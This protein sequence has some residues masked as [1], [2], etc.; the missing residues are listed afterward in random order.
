MSNDLVLR[1]ACL[2]PVTCI[3]TC[4][5][6]ASMGMWRE[7]LRRIP[8]IGFFL[9]EIREAGPCKGAPT[10]FMVASEGDLSEGYG[11]CDPGDCLGDGQTEY[12][13]KVDAATHC[14]GVNLTYI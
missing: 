11:H 8:P 12:R 13:R 4:Y 1:E 5:I 14:S 3:V 10:R 7:S 6:Y 2:R 9:V